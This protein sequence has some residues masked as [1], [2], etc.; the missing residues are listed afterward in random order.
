MIGM[1]VP[2]WVIALVVAPAVGSFAGVVIERLPYGKPFFLSRSECPSC[3]ITLSWRDLVPIASYLVLQ[4]KCRRCEARIKPFHIGVECAALGVAVWAAAAVPDPLELWLDCILGWSLL[5]LAWIDVRHRR[6]PDALTLPL[7]IIGIIVQFMLSPERGVESVLG[8]MCGY[9][10]FWGVRFLYRILRGREGLGLGDVKLLAA[11]G[12]W[13]GWA[14]LPNIVL[15]ASVFGIIFA[16]IEKYNYN[17]HI[18]DYY[19]PFGPFI[20]LALWLIKIYDCY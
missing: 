19:I 20:S 7:V 18:L 6:L 14:A 2:D 4:G 11:A 16:Y 9:A 13:T 3:A 8:A 15:I 10:S 12:A 1:A 17:R 5:I